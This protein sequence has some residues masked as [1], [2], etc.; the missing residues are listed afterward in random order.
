MATKYLEV[1]ELIRHRVH[2]GAYLLKQMPGER[3]LAAEVGVSYMTSRRA[4]QHLIK[5]GV[6]PPRSTGKSDS[7]AHPPGALRIAFV[8]PAFDS[9]VYSLWRSSLEQVVEERGGLVHAVI[10]AGWHDSVIGDAL[11]GDFSGVMLIP[12]MPLPP[13]VVMDRLVRTRRRL[14]VLMHDFSQFGITSVGIDQPE[15]IDKLIEHLFQLGHRHIDCLNT[16]PLNAVLQKRIDVWRE[17]LA[18]R[19][20]RGDLHCNPVKPFEF[21][22]MRAREYFGSILDSG[23]FRATAMFCTTLEGC[24][25]GVIRAA[26]DR[27]IQVGRDLSVCTPDV[28]WRATLMTPSVTTLNTPNPRPYL[29]KALD[30]IANPAR[31]GSR[32]LTIGPKDVPVLIGESTGPAG[33]TPVARVRP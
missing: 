4:I 9:A 3:A 6:L 10:Y 13:Q 30:W 32:S 25:V 7:P 16:E 29:A 8:M 5:E 2:S 20:L 23:T 33:N 22:A 17:S 19:N 26:C 21:P 24:A 11:D 1:A 18:R 15:S 12:T 14:V 31:N 28:P 27:G